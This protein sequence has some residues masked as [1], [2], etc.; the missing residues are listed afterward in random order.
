MVYYQLDHL[1]TP[2]AAHNA[3]GEAVWTAEYE[4]WGR[5]RNE[6]VQPASKST[7]CSVS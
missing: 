6:I 3:K 5:I 1:G 2:I 7:F 4:A